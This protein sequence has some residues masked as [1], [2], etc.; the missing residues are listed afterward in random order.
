M[1]LTHEDFMKHLSDQIYF[2]KRSS[3]NYDQGYTVESK[4]LASHM[5]TLVHDTNSSTSLLIHLRVKLKMKF[6]NTA[7]PETPFGLCG[8]T[9]TTAGGGETFYNPP[10]DNLSEIRLR[11]P[12]VPFKVWWEDM[13]VLSDGKN[14]FSRK[15]LVLA[16]ANKDGGSH[17]D[18]KLPKAYTELTRLNSL[19]VYH[20]EEQSGE[21]VNVIGVEMASIRQVAFELLASLEKQFPNNF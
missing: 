21:L 19:N 10:L 18:D 9:T 20:Q 11:N 3:E 1:K 6:F 5:R 4:S 14:R 8:I 13:K 12:W 17:V 15:D 7:I 16:L 2:L